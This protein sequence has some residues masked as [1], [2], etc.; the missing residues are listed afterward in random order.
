MRRH[1]GFDIFYTPFIDG[2]HPERLKF[3]G[4]DGVWGCSE[5]MEWYA[6]KVSFPSKS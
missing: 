2:Y 4:I 5:V 3:K 6:R 1:Y